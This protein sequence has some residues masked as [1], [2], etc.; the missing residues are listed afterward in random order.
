MSKTLHLAHPKFNVSAIFPE[1][2]LLTNVNQLTKGHCYHTSL[3]DLS[4]LDIVSVVDQFDTINFIPDSF[5]SESDIFFETSV[6]L[7][8]LY[9]RH[10]ITGYVP[11]Q[12]QKFLDL[13]VSTR[14]NEPVLWVF[15]CSHS[16][17]TGLL[18]AEQ[19]FAHHL[20]Q[21]LN[22]PIK[23]IAQPGSSTQWSLRHIVNANFKHG[24]T[25]VWQLTSPERISYGYPPVEVQL[26]QSSIRSLHE[27]YTDQ[28]IL[29]TQLTLFNQGIQYLRSKNVKF[30][31]ISVSAQSP[32][33]YPCLLE[34]TKH[35][36]Y[37]H[38]SGYQLDFGTDNMHM[39]PLSHQALAQRILT[40]VNY[41]N[42]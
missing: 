41:N 23:L 37:C 26:G 27:T 2:V 5:D 7:N 36:E 6:L 12:E 21:Q 15:G 30:S 39:G 17:G 35:P 14:P 18:S 38:A 42:D 11:A 10:K 16:Y 40:H 20:G 33:F 32:I 9:H 34:Y 1:S 13:N 24:D 22:L 28:Q 3:G 31:V 8:Y 4:S 25:V 19:S 29:F